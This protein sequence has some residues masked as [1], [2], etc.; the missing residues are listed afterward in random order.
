MCPKHLH[1]SRLAKF[2]RRGEPALVRQQFGIRRFWKFRMQCHWLPIIVLR[3]SGRHGQ[4]GYVLPSDG[5]KRHVSP[6]FV[7]FCILAQKHDRN[8]VQG[9]VSGNVR[10]VS[11]QASSCGRNCSSGQ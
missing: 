10:Y 6:G 1:S 7:F 2:F 8:P 4:A 5:F 9:S 11:S 3:S